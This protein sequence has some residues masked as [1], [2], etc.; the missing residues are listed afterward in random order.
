MKKKMKKNKLVFLIVGFIIFSLLAVSVKAAPASKLETVKLTREDAQ[1]NSFNKFTSEALGLFGES[2]SL[3][4]VIV[5]TTTHEYD[6]VANLVES[7]GGTVNIE[8]INIDALSINIPA[9]ALL[10]L[11]QSPL[12]SRIFRDDLRE[13]NIFKEEFNTYSLMTD[14]NIAVAPVNIEQA[15]VYPSTYANSYLTDAEAIWAETNAGDGVSVAII[16]TGCWVGPWTTPGGY[17]IYPWY[18]DAVYDGVDLSY[19][20][21]TPNE[22]YG[23]PM[24]HWHG[25]GCAALVAAA[26]E[27]I[28]SPD[29]SWGSAIATYDPEGTWINETTGEIHTYCFGIAPFAEIYAVKVFDHTGGGVPSS[30]IMQGIDAAILEG[31]DIISMSLGGGVGAPGVDPEDLLVDAATE[32]GITVVASAGNEGPAPLR[33]GS[34]G[35]AKTAITVGAAMDPI[36]ERV[37]ADI[38]YF[39]GFGPYYYPHDEIFIADFSCRGPTSDGRNK[40]DV[41]ATGSWTFLGDTPASWP[42]TI[43][44]A[45]GTSFSCPQVAGEAALL[46]AYI[47]NND[48]DLGPSDVKKAIMEGAIPLEGYEDFEQ[49]AGYINCYNS[50]NVIK[51]ME[52]EPKTKGGEYCGHSKCHHHGSYWHPPLELLHFRNG[53]AIVNDISLEPGKYNYFNLWVTEEVD[54]IRITLSGIQYADL[55]EQNPYFYD[56]GVIYLS[57]AVREGIEDYLI[58]L[59]YFYY[60]DEYII[61]VSSDLDFQPGVARLVLAGDFSAF[62]NILIEEMKIEIVKTEAFRCGNWIGI[63]NSGADVDEAQISIFDGNIIREHGKV[64]EGESDVYSF[65]IPE[66]DE[67]QLAIIEL[68]WFRD[69]S[70]WATSDLDILIFNE[71]GYLINID[72]ATGKSPEFVQLTEPGMY[73]IMIDGYQVYF[74]RNEHYCLE[75]THFTSLISKWDSEI[76]ALDWWITLVRVPRRM[77]GLAVIWIHDTL[78]DYWYIADIIKK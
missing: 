15:G 50:L 52:E 35:T 38:A 44:L 51:E 39:P 66:S 47:K 60:Y 68:S 26:V 45:G 62:N 20:V 75:I 70:K 55:S 30:I 19:D 6:L 37:F 17:D 41:V 28:F 57:T 72:G 24:N 4:P 31:V 61:E 43:L 18:W 13:M 46:I 16:D 23:N 12:I 10:A 76:F 67:A 42:Y 7:L 74:N 73:Y 36:H 5:E 71:L 21:G 58:Y 49:G 40:P 8:Y 77:R 65:T 2:S 3:V 34:P 53:E 29:H 9:N 14:A 59:D 25:T 27:I 33:V 64:K 22:G 63:F 1:A 54:S 78:F 32:A 11:A 56:D 48:L 69:W